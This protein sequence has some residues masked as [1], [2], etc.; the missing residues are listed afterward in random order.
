M[1]RALVSLLAVAALALVGVAAGLGVLYASADTSTVGELEFA[2]E[3]RIPPLLEGQAD[4][5]GAKVFDLRLQ[6]GTTELLPGT[7]TET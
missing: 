6:T 2:T 7:T 1:R 3:L 4:G 5:D